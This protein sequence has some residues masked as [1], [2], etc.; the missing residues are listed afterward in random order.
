[1]GITLRS[2][3]KQITEDS[4]RHKFTGEASTETIAMMKTTLFLPCRS[5]LT[6]NQSQ[7]NKCDRIKC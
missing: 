6:V 3:C 4:T 1:M 7:G 2:S 5:P